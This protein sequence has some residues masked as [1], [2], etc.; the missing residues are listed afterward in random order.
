VE[1]YAYIFAPDY[2]EFLRIQEDLLLHI[3]GI[4][5]SAGTALAL[6]TQVTHLVRESHG[7]APRPKEPRDEVAAVA[8]R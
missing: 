2:G 7:N 6:P 8:E 4:V 5:E 1:I 3:L